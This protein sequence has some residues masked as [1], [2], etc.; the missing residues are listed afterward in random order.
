VQDPF[1]KAWLRAEYY[2]LGK[3]EN[4]R[5]QVTQMLW[6]DQKQSS[7]RCKIL[8]DKYDKNREEIFVARWRR[9]ASAV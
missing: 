1:T 3:Y 9:V 7:I 2:E 4:F 6:N 8:Q 5:T